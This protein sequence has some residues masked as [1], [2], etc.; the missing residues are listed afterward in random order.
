MYP[1]LNL[2]GP[3]ADVR[4]RCGDARFIRRHDKQAIE[5]VRWT[6]TGREIGRG[7][8]SVGCQIG[9]P[10]GARGEYARGR[11][12]SRLVSFIEGNPLCE[13]MDLLY[14]FSCWCEQL[15]YILPSILA[16]EYVRRMT[17]RVRCGQ[18]EGYALMP[19]YGR[20]RH[21]FASSRYGSKESSHWTGKSRRSY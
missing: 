2:V 4:E 7:V 17:M 18:K 13:V 6:R 21:K 11:G 19:I 15:E 14:G 9:G 8:R 3:V 16:S 10:P 1:I 20:N 5:R 12:T